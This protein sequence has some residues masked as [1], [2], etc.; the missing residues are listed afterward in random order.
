MPLLDPSAFIP[1]LEKLSLTSTPLTPVFLSRATITPS[2]SP[3][4]F[5]RTLHIGAIGASPSLRVKNTPV[6]LTLTDEILDLLTD[7]LYECKLLENI[8]IVGN[9]KLG[10]RS[11]NNS[12]LSRFIRLVG[13]R[14]KVKFFC[15]IGQIMVTSAFCLFLLSRFSTSL[16]SR[17]LNHRIC[18]AYPLSKH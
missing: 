12:S 9:T 15:F 4:K 14:C 13:R 3:W 11:K 1:E 16:P 8:S 18:L 7:G 10:L 17:A 2:E 5:L 6:S